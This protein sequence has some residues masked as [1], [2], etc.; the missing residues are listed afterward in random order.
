MTDRLVDGFSA[1]GARLASIRARIAAV[2]RPFT[3][4]VDVL[5]VTK[6][7][8]GAADDAPLQS[9]VQVVFFR[10]GNHFLGVEIAA[11]RIAPL[12]PQQRFRPIAIAVL[13]PQLGLEVK[14]RVAP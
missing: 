4:D 11:G 8:D 7:F 1:V 10:H 9:A 12:N 13:Q 14:R 5:P 3:H 6:G 2:D